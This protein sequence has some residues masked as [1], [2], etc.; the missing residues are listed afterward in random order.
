MGTSFLLAPYDY[1]GQVVVVTGGASGMGFASAMAF[2]DAGAT[3]VIADVADAK[4]NQ[5]S[6]LSYRHTDVTVEAEI[7]GLAAAT[8]AEYGRIDVWVSAA[9]VLG[10]RRLLHEQTVANVEHV[11]GVN[12][13]GVVWGTKHAIRSFRRTENPRGV[14]INF[15]SV[16]SYRVKSAKASIYAASK[17]AV[18]SLTKSAA[19]EYGA[20]GIRVNAIAPGPI[21][22]PM[23]RDAAGNTWPPDIVDE[24]PLGR[25]GSAE[26][27]AEAVLWLA[28]DAAGYITGATLPVDGGWLAP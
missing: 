16:Q 14:I 2:A 27:V 3:V 5:T 19:L 6:L 12:V 11:L 10:Q 20:E 8:M 17:A 9:G 1:S 26:E 24:T 28:S 13:A 25:L 7:D 21:D 23:L 18:V 22:T 4:L 15:A